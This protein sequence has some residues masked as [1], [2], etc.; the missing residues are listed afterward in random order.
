MKIPRILAVFLCAAVA[1]LALAIIK[2]LV[3]GGL[4]KL[5]PVSVMVFAAS[6]FG[7]IAALIDW[8]LLRGLFPRANR[9]PDAKTKAAGSAA[10]SQPQAQRND[11]I[12][13]PAR[14]RPIVFREICPP[15]ATTK[16]SFY[17]GAPIG[18]ATLAWPRVRN[19]PGDTPLS[20]I[21][22]WDSV[23]LARQDVTGL[24]PRD[25]ALYLFADLGWGDFQFLHAP[26][27]THGWQA[28]PLPPGLPPIYG[29]E[30]AYHVPYCSARIA[31]ESRDPPQL[32]P[33]WPFLPIAF[34]Y[35]APPDGPD[36][37]PGEE[38]EGWYWH[39][40]E[41]TAEALLGLE[42]PMGVPP[43]QRLDDKPQSR[44]ERPFAAFP[45]DYA[46]VR[47][48]AAKVLE[49]LRHPE[50]LLRE[51]AENDRRERF[52]AWKN[53]AAQRYSSA[54]AHRPGARVEQSQSDEIWRWIEGLEPVLGPGWNSLVEECANVSLGLESEAA[55]SLPPGLVAVCTGH[56]R[57]ASAY[58]RDE[59]PDHSQPDAF[60]RWEAR[61]A[62]GSLKEIRWLHAPCP[63]HMFGPPSCV[64]GY[65]EEYLKDWVLLLELSSR[66]P[67]GHEFGEGVLQFMILPSDLREGRFDKTKLIASAY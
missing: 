49:Q 40:G 11:P 31:K 62:E 35:P 3:V 26:G 39:E 2:A 19:K 65:V 66:R 23:E 13:E 47:I 42:H 51:A 30:G 25:G 7:L 36:S 67:I 9:R 21:M 15:S 6:T 56:H 34:S 57:L 5:P 55:G 52:E 43:A 58:L 16:L 32:L 59:Y 14:L 50:R 54:T 4:N 22:Q 37:P 41:S 29:D 38:G 48:V 44:F 17:G 12:I 53:E 27:P 45:H 20:F 60:K 46:A 61:K 10:V 18:P 1:I 8:G 64:Q 63:N 33:K 28:L 24:L